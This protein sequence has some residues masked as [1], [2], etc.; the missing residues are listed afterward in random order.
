MKKYMLCTSLLSGL[1]VMPAIASTAVPD[2]AYVKAVLSQAKTYFDNGIQD[3]KVQVSAEIDKAT[4][5]AKVYTD[6]V[7]ESAVQTVNTA[8]Q[9]GVATVKTYA[10]GLVEQTKDASNLT[11]G[12]VSIDRLPVGNVV[13]TVSAGDD[14]RFDTVSLGEPVGVVGNEQRVVIWVEQ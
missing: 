3:A 6:T 2:V 8:I 4:S 1:F 12:T 13:S 10:D 14:I 11:S 5:D 9:T 7:V